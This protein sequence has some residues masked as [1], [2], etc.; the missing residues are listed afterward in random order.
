MRRIFKSRESGATS[1]ELVITMA[2]WEI[3]GEVEKRNR[4]AAKQFFQ[5]ALA[6]VGH[7]PEQVTTDG[8][9]SYPRAVRAHDG[10]MR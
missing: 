2:I 8:H 3:H 7:A 1:I 5:Q 6:V 4:D 10:R 9:R